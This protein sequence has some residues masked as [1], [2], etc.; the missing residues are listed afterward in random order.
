MPSEGISKSR[1]ASNPVKSCGTRKLPMDGQRRPST[2]SRAFMT[3]VFP[4]PFG[5]TIAVR[6]ARGIVASSRALK[7]R[8]ETCLI[9]ATGSSWGELSRGGGSERP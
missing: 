1:K 7:F 4:A 6:G 8:S 5:P 9:N 3:L 2:I